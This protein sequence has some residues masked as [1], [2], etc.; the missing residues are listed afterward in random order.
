MNKLE[1]VEKFIELRAMGYTFDE[2]MEQLKISKPTLIKWGKIYHT[3]IAEV[4]KKLTEELADRIVL[5]NSK[6]FE[7]FLDTTVRIAKDK[8][9]DEEAKKRIYKRAS[10]KM[11]G[12][13]KREMKAIEID[14]WNNGNIRMAKIIWDELSH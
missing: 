5:K 1:K 9:F 12:L 3:R 8:N 10:Q 11:Y 13:L 4:E 6:F 14:F 2:I 7:V